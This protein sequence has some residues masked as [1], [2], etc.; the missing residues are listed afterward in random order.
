MKKK[1]TYK[2][3]I[4]GERVEWISSKPRTD[5]PLE[6]E[7][8]VWEEDREEPRIK[9]ERRAKAAAALREIAKRGG[10]PEIPGPVAWQREIRK[11]RPLPGREQ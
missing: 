10:V 1:Y 8:S 5:V 11:D 6:V 3:V 7:V 4:D 2:A 9:E